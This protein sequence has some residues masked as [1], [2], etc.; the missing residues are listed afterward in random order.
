MCAGMFSHSAVAGMKFELNDGKDVLEVGGYVKLDAR[1]VDGTVP[2]RNWWMG[3]LAPG[4]TALSEDK[5]TFK[6]KAQESRFN[7]K[8]THGNVFAYIE[9]DFVDPAT[10]QGSSDIENFTNRAN[11]TLRHA[12]I[13]YKPVDKRSGSWLLGQSWSTIQNTSAFMEAI[14][15]GGPLTSQIFMRQTQVRYTKGNFQIALENPKFF[16]PSGGDAR[17]EENNDTDS[18]PDLIAR[19]NFKG[20][21][22]NVSV[23]GLYRQID[24]GFGATKI[25]EAAFGGS[26]AGRINSGERDDLRFSYNK[27][28]LGRY[29]G[30]SLSLDALPTAK[31]TRLE[32]SETYSIGYRHFWKDSW[33]STLYYGHAKTELSKKEISQWGVNLMKNVTKQLSIGVEVGNYSM[34]YINK[35]SDYL[36][37]S[38]KFVI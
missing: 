9:L 30:L 14:S 11:N 35:D 38:A 31:G 26:I 4:T 18:M 29:I 24:A 17:I 28:E 15:F 13:V 34:E 19:Y 8:Y 12:F 16:T 6:L 27:G 23:S 5:S 32:D 22:G 2:Y 37:F 25:D 1:Y 33:R 20:K 7:F 21:W 36:Q 10:S 3:G